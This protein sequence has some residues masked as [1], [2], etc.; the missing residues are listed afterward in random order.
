MGW[1]GNIV[2]QFKNGDVMT[3]NNYAITGVYKKSD[4]K[5]KII[6]THESSLPPEIIKK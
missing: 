3:M 4:A 2:A 5:W 1:T 6:H